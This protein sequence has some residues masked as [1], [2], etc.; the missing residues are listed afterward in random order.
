M[1][2][3]RK[4]AERLARKREYRAS[5]EARVLRTTV[6]S[7]DEAVEKNAAD[8]RR[9]LDALPGKPE[10]KYMAL[11]RCGDGDLYSYPIY[12][13]ADGFT[14]ALQDAISKHRQMGRP[15][16]EG[17]F[18]QGIGSTSFSPPD[19][20]VQMMAMGAK[21]LVT[22]RLENRRSVDGELNGAFGQGGQQ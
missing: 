4:Q 18:V 12:G 17:G 20:L 13:C 9:Q 7:S 14:A 22:N 5:R 10:E 21:V 11:L 15:E 19:V 2:R 8:L 16:I 6:L 3:E 1:S